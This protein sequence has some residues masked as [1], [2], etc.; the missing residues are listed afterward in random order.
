MN[1][2]AQGKKPWRVLLF[3]LSF[4]VLIGALVMGSM[5]SVQAECSLCVEFRGGRQCRTGR[6]A[7]ESD[8]RSAA[9]RAACAVMAGG[10]AESIACDNTPATEVQC[11]G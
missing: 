1:D 8:A 5:Q 11:S 10:M 2:K 3:V 6:G 7:N 4:A 9:Q